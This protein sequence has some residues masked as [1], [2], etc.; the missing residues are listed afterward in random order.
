ML[1]FLTSVFIV[2]KIYHLLIGQEEYTSFTF[3]GM[4]HLQILQVFI[5]LLNKSQPL[6]ISILLSDIVFLF[7]GIH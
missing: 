4:K 7:P 1:Y 5:V 2:S 3:S 6:Q